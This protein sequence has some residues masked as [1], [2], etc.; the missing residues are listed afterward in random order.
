MTGERQKNT[1]F[2]QNSFLK[3]R[4]GNKHTNHINSLSTQI[5]IYTAFPP[6]ATMRFMV[7]EMVSVRS[8]TARRARCQNV[9]C[10][11]KVFPSCAELYFHAQT[12]ADQRFGPRANANGP[13]LQLRPSNVGGL[14]CR[15]CSRAHTLA[16]QRLSCAPT[17]KR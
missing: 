2:F 11:P 14:T 4:G 7:L 12:L 5:I 1:F 16:G 6:T 10:T 9:S 3:K 17:L 15:L 8:I 13:T